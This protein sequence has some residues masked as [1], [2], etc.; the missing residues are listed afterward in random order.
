M[1]IRDEFDKDLITDVASRLADYKNTLIV[2]R[3]KSFEGHTDKVAPWYNTK[4]RIEPYAEELIKRMTHP[5][6]D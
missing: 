3:S 5:S 1:T 6:I 4:Y 2:M